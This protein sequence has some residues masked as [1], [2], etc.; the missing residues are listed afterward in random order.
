MARFVSI[1]VL[2]SL[3]FSGVVEAQTKTFVATVTPISVAQFEQLSQLSFGNIANQAG[4]VCNIDESGG[5]SGSCIA[6]EDAAGVGRIQVSGLA[7]NQTM[8]ILIEGSSDG[9]LSLI[10][11]ATLQG[12]SSQTSPIVNGQQRS[13]TTS[14]DGQNITM[15]VFGEISLLTTLP[16]NESRDIEFSVTINIE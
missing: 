5:L 2:I 10:P 12:T 16:E 1:C 9:G 3:V 6:E 4:A 7:A 15:T 11:T 14:S 8:N 13:F